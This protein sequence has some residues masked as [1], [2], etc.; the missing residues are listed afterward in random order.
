[1][2]STHNKADLEKKKKVFNL[3]FHL[4]HTKAQYI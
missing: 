2:G 1:M 3:K 4:I